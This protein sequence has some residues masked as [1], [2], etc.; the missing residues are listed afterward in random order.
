[1]AIVRWDPFG[2]MTRLQRVMDRMLEEPFFRPYETILPT[3]PAMAV[4]LQE[5]DNEYILKATVPGVQPED[6]DITVSDNLLT[7]RADIREEKE[8]REGTYHLKERR[9]GTCCRSF[10]LPT[11]VKA[12]EAKATFENGILTLTLPKAERRG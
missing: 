12:E 9:F 2:E 4:D 1:M 7:I 10:T 11:P 8:T 5:A 3:V 6:V